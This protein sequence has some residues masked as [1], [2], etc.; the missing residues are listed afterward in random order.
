MSKPRLPYTLCEISRHGKTVWYFRKGKGR[1]SR[2]NGKPG[3][4]EFLKS[5]QAAL[6]NADIPQR[7]TRAKPGT[8]AW[9]FEGYKA[10]A[11]FKALAPST[12]RVRANILDT[13]AQKE[14]EDGVP[15]GRFPLTA[16]TKK[17]IRR[18]RDDRAE[19]P[20][21]ANSY[22]KT[23]RAVFKW[24]KDVAGSIDHNPAADVPLIKT[25]SKGW[26]PWTD[27]EIEQYQ[28]HWPLGTKERLAFDLLLFTGL[29]RSDV[30]RLGRQHIR[31][32]MIVIDTLKTGETAYIDIVSELDES[33]AAGPIGDLV[34]LVTE[35]GKPY[36]GDGFGNWFRRKVRETG[37]VGKSPHGVR[38][39]AASNMANA[40]ATEHG[41][42][43]VFGWETGRQAQHYTRSANR[44]KI[45]REQ[46]AGLAR[47][48]NTNAPHLSPNRP[49]PSK[50]TK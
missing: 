2:L 43:A 45:A 22:V 5:Y 14:N 9:L 34:F 39:A 16:I 27:A 42:M 35:F 8:L 15:A 13:I 32:G 7:R 24:A 10:S 29:R 49:A 4:A 31:D 21:A 37:I 33:I 23:L 3:S 38:K 17:V 18:G 25:G 50:K 20:E 48:G 44:Q 30:V 1:R 11:E 46:S 12:R 19:K 26:Q 47:K 40:G 36:S 28:T 41:L 6:A